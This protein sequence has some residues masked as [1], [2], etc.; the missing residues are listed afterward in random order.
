MRRTTT[1]ELGKTYQSGEIIVREGDPGNCMFVI[2]E[3]EVEVI[4]VIN[5]EVHRLNVLEAGDFF[6]E[7][8]IFEK[9]A[10]N[11]TVRALTPTRLLTVD[12][13]TFMSRIEEDPSLAFRIVQTLSRRVQQMSDEVIRLRSE[14]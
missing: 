6:G 7:A 4:R 14:G 5:G 13:K 2:Q 10:R 1:G 11:A 8:A 12:K 3:G 9:E